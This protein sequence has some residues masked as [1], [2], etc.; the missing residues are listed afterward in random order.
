MKKVKKLIALA[1]SFAMM[2]SIVACESDNSVEEVGSV[3]EDYVDALVEIN[4]GDIEDLS[5]EIDDESIEFLESISEYAD[6]NPIT[7]A[8]LATLSA[9]IDEESIEATKKDA[10]GCV[11]VEFSYVDLNALAEDEEAIVDED[12]FVDA[13]ADAEVKAV[14][15]TIEFEL[16]D[17]DWLVSNT[18]EIIEE[19]YSEIL[20]FEI[21]FAV[22]LTDYVEGLYWYDLYSGYYFDGS[23]TVENLF[24]IEADLVLDHEALLEQDDD[25]IES[26]L[27]NTIEYEVYSN[28]SLIDSG[29]ASISM[30]SSLYCFEII[31]EATSGYVPE[32]TYTVTVFDEDGNAI[33]T[34]PELY[35]EEVEPV[36]ET[37]ASYLAWFDTVNGFFEDYAFDS[38]IYPY[39]EADIVVGSDI[40]CD[41]FTYIA[42]Y[43]GEAVYTSGVVT[44]V[45]YTDVTC[46]EMTIYPEDC[47]ASDVMPDGYYYVEIYDN[48]GNLYGV[49]PVATVGDVEAP[50]VENAGVIIG[51]EVV[52]TGSG[53]GAA[54][55]DSEYIQYLDYYYWWANSSG[56]LE[57]DMITLSEYEDINFTYYYEVY[58]NEQLIYTSDLRDD[59][60][61]WL[62]N[63]FYPSDIGLSSFDLNN[64]VYTMVVY[65]EGGAEICRLDSNNLDDQYF[66]N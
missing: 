1:V 7:E 22:P 49:S 63:Y 35:V 38:G 34:S 56:V 19:L 47:G 31:Y 20:E 4:S 24:A 43:N 26:V 60:G 51:Q 45:S 14:T 12:T 46:V 6:N 36:I 27:D 5:Y 29:S 57:L 53:D 25:V 32:G 55:G 21:E 9:E 54:T 48:A 44:P 41:E 10:E 62:E 28:G 17:E 15:I 61:H 16:D 2:L 50:E 42:F 37:T 23:A 52:S 18:D 33:A 58:E 66:G 64:T 40:P 11:D 8:A 65:D 39:L 13:I 30:Y 3:A 59:S